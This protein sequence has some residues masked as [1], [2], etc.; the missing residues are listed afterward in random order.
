M[1]IVEKYPPKDDRFESNAEY[2]DRVREELIES[3]RTIEEILGT[4]VKFLC[5]PGGAFNRTTLRVAEEVGYVATTTHYQDQER[6]NIYGQNPREI[7]RIGCGTPWKWR[8]LRAFR[9]DPGFFLAVLNDFK[10]DRSSIWK[11]RLYKLKYAF[12]HY[13]FGT[14]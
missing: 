12:R 4:S 14:A 5:W 7:N 11:M 6:R 2:E 8:G 10:G 13:L 1:S 3:Q 9:T